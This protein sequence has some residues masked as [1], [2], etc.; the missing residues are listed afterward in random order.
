[1]N[2]S[3]TREIQLTGKQL[4]FV[5]MSTLLVAVVIFLLGVWVGRGMGLEPSVAARRAADPADP[6]SP[7]VGTKSGAD[8]PKLSYPEVLQGS[9]SA[10]AKSQPE[11]PPPPP[12]PVTPPSAT[13][14]SPKPAPPP[15]T[16]KPAT[17]STSKPAIPADDA[18]AVQLGAFSSKANADG[19]AAELKAKG[20]PAYV[21]PGP[22]FKVR[23]GP[24]AKRE[25]AEQVAARLRKDPK[26][27][28]PRVTSTR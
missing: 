25:A 5:F 9:G 18:W 22:Q 23:V 13:K 14:D 11:A 26:G 27:Y 21:T 20:Y 15:A 28:A 10:A 24:F 7:A 19:M 16:T 17:A 6:T 8:G 1:M 12:A 3:R 2:E 4:V